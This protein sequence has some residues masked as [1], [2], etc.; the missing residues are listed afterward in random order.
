MIPRGESGG[1]AWDVAAPAAGFGYSF[2]ATNVAM[3]FLKEPRLPDQLA[4]LTIMGGVIRGPDDLHPEV[5][6]PICTRRR[7]SAGAASGSAFWSAQ[8]RRNIRATSFLD[9]PRST[10]ANTFSL[11][12]FEC[13]FYAGS[14][15]SRLIP[16]QA[17]V[18][19]TLCA[20][21]IPHAHVHDVYGCRFTF[22]KLTAD[23]QPP[24]RLDI[25]TSTAQ[26][27]LVTVPA[28]AVRR[29][30]VQSRLAKGLPLL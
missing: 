7:P 9:M 1:G 22:S 26:R 20:A 17:A 5:P 30:W 23:E 13:G 19:T 27:I 18:R 21:A 28:M 25:D 29:L 14:L 11:R 16:T 3:A 24:Q 8:R 2:A 4:Q 15:A 12:S 6:A 10:A